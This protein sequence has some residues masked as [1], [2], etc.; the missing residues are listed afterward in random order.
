MLPKHQFHRELVLRFT[1]SNGVGIWNYKR[2]VDLL[3]LVRLLSDQWG[4]CSDCSATNGKRKNA[5]EKR[6]C[7]QAVSQKFPIKF[8][9]AVCKILVKS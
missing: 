7:K 8:S 2:R 1:I 9:K 3:R 5:V 4:E 6:V